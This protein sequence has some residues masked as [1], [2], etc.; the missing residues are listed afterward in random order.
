MDALAAAAFAYGRQGLS[1]PDG[2]EDVVDR[3][4]QAGVGEEH[5]LQALHLEH[6]IGFVSHQPRCRGSR[7]SR[8]ASPNRLAPNTARLMAMPGKITSQ[9]AVRTYSAADSESM[10][11]HDGYGSGM[12][13]PRKESEASVRI[14]EP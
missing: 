7:M 9:G 13:S 2:R 5:R 12:P 14:V 3:P 6:E 4:N 1:A 10:R 8:R 11:P